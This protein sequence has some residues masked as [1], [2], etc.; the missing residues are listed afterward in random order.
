MQVIADLVDETSQE[1]VL[2]EEGSRAQELDPAMVRSQTDHP[3]VLLQRQTRPQGGRGLVH[4][5]Y[6]VTWLHSIP[7]QLY[8]LQPDLTMYA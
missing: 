4:G 6:T 3:H 8:P 1:G 2:G 5:N 7:P